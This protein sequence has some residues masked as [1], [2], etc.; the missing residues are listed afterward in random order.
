MSSNFARDATWH[1]ETLARVRRNTRPRGPKL[2]TE[3]ANSRGPDGSSAL[4]MLATVGT[5][6]DALAVLGAGA[7]VNMP[8]LP[9][10]PEGR[11]WAD[12]WQETTP[13]TA[14]AARTGG[15]DG[16]LQA[17]I[18][19]G[20]SNP[21]Y[22]DLLETACKYG[23]ARTV[24]YLLV[25]KASPCH[26]HAPGGR[27]PIHIAAK[28]G[29]ASVINVL[30]EHVA[31]PSAT[32][33]ELHG[34]PLSAAIHGGHAPAV[35][36]LLRHGATRHCA[37]Y[38]AVAGADPHIVACV[39][40]YK[41]SP[42]DY[43]DVNGATALH[44]AAKRNHVSI[45]R[46]LLDANADPRA[47]ERRA[48][49]SQGPSAL[50]HAA[51]INSSIL[52][53]LIEYKADVNST[54][55][56]M[57][58]LMIAAKN[59]FT[60]HIETLITSGANATNRNLNGHTAGEIAVT[61]G[62]PDACLPTIML[63][64]AAG[65]PHIVIPGGVPPNRHI[66]LGNWHHH[67]LR[68]APLQH[69]AANNWWQFGGPLRLH[70]GWPRLVGNTGNMIG[71][72]RQS[73]MCVQTKA[74]INRLTKGWSPKNQHPAKSDCHRRVYTIMLVSARMYNCESPTGMPPEMWMHCLRFLMFE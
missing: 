39:L 3:R 23:N 41:A 53:M 55:S 14:A 7:D 11:T 66:G 65:A 26:P 36:A 67:T 25:M 15:T 34:S 35:V 72:R 6:A 43:T 74:L 51:D 70:L 57:T 20:A 13:L 71:A 40:R 21:Q 58:P 49:G 1:A 10:L 64:A 5:V 29:H 32:L 4:V 45:C 63:L 42:L 17:L 18:T 52:K 19:A 48:A 33:G 2:I 46:L 44:V 68:W 28:H 61:M 59:H 24:R 47:H 16:M 9:F 38:E 27:L 50:H 62:E 22:Q 73:G 69:I 60:D 31:D 12:S 30:M 37:L 54:W 56:G 8:S